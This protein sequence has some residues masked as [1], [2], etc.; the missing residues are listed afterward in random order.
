MHDDGNAKRDDQKVEVSAK[1]EFF[2]V[3]DLEWLDAD[4][5]PVNVIVGDVWRALEICR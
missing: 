3:V 5:G 1:S 2:V 4:D